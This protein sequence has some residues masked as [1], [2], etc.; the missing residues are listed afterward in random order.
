MTSPAPPE[1]DRCQLEQPTEPML[2]ALSVC[3]AKTQESQVTLPDKTS[4]S[5]SNPLAWTNSDSAQPSNSTSLRGRNHTL[6]WRMHL[7]ALWRFSR[8]TSPEGR[9]HEKLSVLTLGVW[10]EALRSWWFDGRRS[11]GLD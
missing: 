2:E 10:G 4:R 8:I 9:R 7:K 6:V 1:P 3:T 11:H 5:N